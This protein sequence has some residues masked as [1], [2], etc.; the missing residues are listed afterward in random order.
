MSASCILDDK[1]TN[2]QLVS[3]ETVTRKRYMYIHCTVSGVQK[4]T[5]VQQHSCVTTCT[6]ICP[7]YRELSA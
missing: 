1:I 5:V 4:N 6:C 7:E 2:N 3:I